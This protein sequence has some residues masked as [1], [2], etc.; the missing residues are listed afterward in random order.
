MMAYPIQHRVTYRDTWHFDSL[1]IAADA[2]QP[3]PLVEGALKSKI[4]HHDNMVSPSNGCRRYT[5]VTPHQE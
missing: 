3:A 4:Q 1:C 5:L 2:R